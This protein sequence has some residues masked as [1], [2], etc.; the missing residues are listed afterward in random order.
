MVMRSLASDPPTRQHSVF[1]SNQPRT[2]RNAPRTGVCL[3]CKRPVGANREDLEISVQAC[4]DFNE[5][6][7]NVSQTSVGCAQAVQL[8][9]AALGNDRQATTKT[10]FNA[11]V[12]SIAISSLLGA[13]RR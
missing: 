5:Y 3:V 7:V 9:C 11:L 13:E 6:I 1:A 8:N 12:G 2:A 4:R 10:N